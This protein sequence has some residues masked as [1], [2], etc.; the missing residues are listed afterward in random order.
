MNNNFSRAQSQWLDPPEDD[1]ICEVEA[2]CSETL[3]RDITG[4]W[5]CKNEFCPTKFPEGSVEREMAELLLGANETVRSLV[6]K[7]KRLERL[8]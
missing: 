8:D 2:G 3:V 6:E 7:F 1:P 4:A 5:V